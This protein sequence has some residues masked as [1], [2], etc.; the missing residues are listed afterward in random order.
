VFRESGAQLAQLYPR[1]GELLAD[2]EARARRVWESEGGF[3]GRAAGRAL[4]G[5]GKRLRPGILLLSAEC[6]GG[7]TESSSVLAAVVEVIHTASLVHDDVVDGSASRRG[8]RSANAEWGNKVS[9]LLGD[10][11]LAEGLGLLSAEDR[12]RYVPGLLQ[13]ARWMCE[14]QIRELL[15]AGRRLTEEKYLEIA[16]AKTG[17]LFGLCGRMGV[18]SGGG[19]PEMAAALERFGQSFGVAFQV[20][21]DILDLVGSD[22]RSGKSEGRDL[23]ERKSTLPLILA[24]ERGDAETQARLDALLGQEAISSAEALEVRELAEAAGAIERSWASVEEW[25][26]AARAALAGAP[27]SEARR[28]LAVIAGER[29]PIPVMG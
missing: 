17:A 16:R 24:A 7:A 12:V 28:A 11:L 29:F 5:R 2:V 22:G 10:Y 23:A 25:L 15:S 6:A 20:A 19:S 3:L 18:E 13:V 4:S 26:A 9:V 8:R 21:D 27:E 1:L 14:G